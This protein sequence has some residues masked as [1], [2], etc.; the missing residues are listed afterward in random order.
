MPVYSRHSERL[1]TQ[2]I[3]SILLDPEL[4]EKKMCSMQPVFVV[5]LSK[6]SHVRDIYCDDMGSWKY[7]G[8][9]RSWIDVDEDGFVTS[10]GKKKPV[11]AENP[12]H[13]TKK[14]FY[15]K[16][17]IDLKKIVAILTGNQFL[18]ALHEDSSAP[19]WTFHT[20]YLDIKLNY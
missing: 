20:N 11:E 13:I 10:H 2:E 18:L 14:Y 5:D 6:L 19:H 8:V 7:N 9:Y 4:D 17:S 16:T 12:Y 3:V 15:H 1:D